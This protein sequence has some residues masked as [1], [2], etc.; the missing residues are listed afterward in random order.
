M[1]AAWTETS[2]SPE[3]TDAG[4][5]REANALDNENRGE[6]LDRRDAIALRVIAAIYGRQ[7]P[8]PTDDSL[9]SV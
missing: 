7:C 4:R 8:L 9:A 3:A 6:Y 1:P 2:V 5:A